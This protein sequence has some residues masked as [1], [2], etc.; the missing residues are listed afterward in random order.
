M[1]PG[2]I[3]AIPGKDL[4]GIIYSVLLAEIPPKSMDLRYGFAIT[5]ITS[6]LEECIITER[7]DKLYKDSHRKKQWN[8]TDGR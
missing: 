6:R 8:I 2:V 3:Y 4:N 7:Y 5:A 1:I